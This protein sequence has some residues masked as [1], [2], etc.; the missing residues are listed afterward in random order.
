MVDVPTQLQS[1]TRTYRLEERDGQAV[2]VQSLEQTYPAALADVWDALTT[3][4]RIQ[5]WFLPISGDLRLGRRYQFEGN[6]GGEILTCEPPEDGAAEFSVTWEMMGAVSW[7]T[8]RL[9][10]DGEQA[11]RVELEHLSNVADIPAEMW[12]TFGP[13]ATGVGWDGGLLGLG[14]H[15]GATEGSLAPSEAEA[16]TLTDEGRSFYRGAADGWAV[17]HTASGEDAEVAQ[18]R[19]DATYGFYTGTDQEG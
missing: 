17:A 13:G 10:A 15:L 14:L 18:Q 3:A 6:A 1:V 5:R 19:A 11:T 9:A 2:H 8:L 12:E 4:E 16:W 7:V